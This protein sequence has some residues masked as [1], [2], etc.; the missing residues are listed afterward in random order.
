MTSSMNVSLQK[1]SDSWRYLLSL[2]WL[3]Y[4]FGEWEILDRIPTRAR[5]FSP[6]Q[7]TNTGSR[8]QPTGL[9][10]QSTGLRLLSLDAKPSGCSAD[11]SCS[12]SAKIKNSWSY[13]SLP[14]VLMACP[15][16]ILPFLL[17]TKTNPD[18]RKTYCFII[19]HRLSYSV[20]KQTTH[21]I[22]YR[23]HFPSSALLGLQSIVW[24]MWY[25]IRS[26]GANHR[27][28]QKRVRETTLQ[29]PDPILTSYTKNWAFPLCLMCKLKTKTC[30]QKLPKA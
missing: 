5:S 17:A 29:T 7:S 10:A 18:N 15:G 16:T 14:S 4:R 8:A 12:P 19:P 9:R 21:Y 26:S 13:T 30:R 23:Y 2:T 28:F 25:M 27:S 6:L 11:H 22:N 3:G 24:V 1:N 20:V